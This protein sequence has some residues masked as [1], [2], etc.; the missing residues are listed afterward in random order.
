MHIRHLTLAAML[1][2]TLPTSAANIAEW[3]MDESSGDILDSRGLHLAGTPTGAID[4]FLP[5][6]PNGAYGSISVANA[7]G[8]AINIGPVAEYFTIGLSNNNPVMNIDRTGS[9]T[10][11][12][13]MSLNTI[14]LNATYRLLSSGSTTGADGGWGFGFKNTNGVNTLRM[15]TY[16]VADNDSDA[17]SGLA[18]NT[19]YHIAATYNSGA[20]SYYLNGD[21][22][23]GAD[24]SFFNNDNTNARLNVGA[25]LSGLDQSNAVFDGLRVYD[26]ALDINGIRTAAVDSVSV[27]EP[28]TG[29][30]GSLGLAFVLGRRRRHVCQ[31]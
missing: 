4:Y 25:R 5:G 24:N 26:T 21:L 12:G 7:G 31:S 17:L 8:T 3:R 18:A 1:V 28:T 27:P 20:I 29:L 11:M 13:W 15:T 19:W 2:A 9:F 6:V 14:T 23:G 10:V 16:G 30:L 22:L